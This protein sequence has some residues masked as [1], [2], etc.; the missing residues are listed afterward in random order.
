MGSTVTMTAPKSADF[1]ANPRA[2][3]SMLDEAAQR[4]GARPA[5]DFLGRGWSWSDIATLADRAAAGLQQRGVVKGTRVGLCLPNTHYFIVM[6]YAILKA[7]GTVVNFN[8]LYTERELAT[9][10]QSAGTR[11]MV[12]LDVPMIQ[13]KISALVAQGLLDQVVVCSMAQ[14]LPML[15]SWAFRLLKSSERAAIP[16]TKTYVRFANLIAGQSKPAPVSINPLED[17]AALQFTGGTTGVPK[18]AML[19]HGNITT[20]VQQVLAGSPPLAEGG[21]RIM[22]VLPFFHVF[23]MTAV[24]NLGVAIGAELVLMPRLDIKMLMAAIERKRP[25]I[26]P[27]V[28]TLFTAI[29]NAAGS[30]MDLSFIKFCISGGAAISAEAADRFE[31]LSQCSILEGYGLSEASPVVTATPPER[32]KRNSVGTALPGTIIEIRDPEQPERIL[33]QGEKGEI[34]VRGPQIMKGYLDRPDETAKSMIDGAL[35]TGD[36][37]YLDADGYLFIVDRIKDL[38]L[39]SGYNVYPRVI[40]EAA[41]QHPAVQDAIAIGIADSYRGQAP[42]LFVTLRTGAQATEAEILEFLKSHLNKIEIPKA[43]EIRDSLPKTLVGKLSKKELVAEEAAKPQ[44]IKEFFNDQDTG[45][46]AS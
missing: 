2:A 8:P 14:A 25:T 42:K 32:I 21:E 5:V 39:C 37:G 1:V 36:I 4:F 7:G 35:R 29:S 45:A 15:K 18:A 46:K 30:G 19:T 16:A 38:I 12:S 34:C 10:A 27:G 11:I 20:N 28:P 17:V 3:G 41:Y 9:Q 13:D 40:E 22:G 24:M 43:I 33:P 23:A 6:Y 26:V 31:R 44:V